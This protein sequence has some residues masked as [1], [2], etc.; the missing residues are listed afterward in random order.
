MTGDNAQF[1]MDLAIRPALGVEDFLVSASNVAA[2]ETVDRWPDWPHW[3]LT[4]TGPE[5][6]GKTHLAN[7]WR[8]KSNAALV[9]A[10]DVSD[11]LVATLTQHRALVVENLETGLGD[12]RAMFHLLNLAR[13]HAFSILM[14]SRAPPG[15]LTIELPDLRSRLRATPVAVILSPDEHLLQGVLIKHFADR[16]LLVEPHVVAYI[17]RH[18]E[19]SMRAAHETV[20]ELDRRSLAAHRRVTR[21]L[22]AEVLRIG[23]DDDADTGDV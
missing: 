2:L 9:A 18:M 6:S 17:M 16:Q 12:E 23:Q 14:T 22:A 13:E 5:M 11:A 19:R 8:I 20:A 10:S 21:V 4:V 1:I 15:E 7:V 3:A